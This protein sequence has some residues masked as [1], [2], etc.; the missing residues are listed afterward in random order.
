LEAPHTI[1]VDEFIE[2]N[3]AGKEDAVS[4]MIRMLDDLRQHG[5]ECR[6]IKNLTGTPL[7]ELKPSARG[8]VRGGARVYFWITPDDAAGVVNCEVKDHQA[9]AS[10][11]KLKVALE[12]YNAHQNGI[13]VFNSA[14]L[15]R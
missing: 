5:R 10:M 15:R 12:V 2:L 11:Q 8:G 9:P 14:T 7:M 6:Y 13:P 4:V 3:L 1:L